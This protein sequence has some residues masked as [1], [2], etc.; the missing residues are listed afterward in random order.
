MSVIS[1]QQFYWGNSVGTGLYQIT[2]PENLANQ[3]L[4]V[5]L[6]NQDTVTTTNGT[7]CRQMNLQKYNIRLTGN[8]GYNPGSLIFNGVNQNASSKSGYKVT[9]NLNITATNAEYSNTS[10]THTYSIYNSSYTPTL[11]TYTLETTNYYTGVTSTSTGSV[12]VA[13]ITSLTTITLPVLS[14][15]RLTVSMP[16][17]SDVWISESESDTY[18]TQRTITSNDS[19]TIILNSKPI[20]IDDDIPL[21]LGGD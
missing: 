19:D 20:I 21:G 17:D 6:S 9:S 3:A 16:S 5:T 10:Y 1:N 14:T 18:I 2:Y 11:V 4:T 7:T 15:Y 8:T 13:S 12:T